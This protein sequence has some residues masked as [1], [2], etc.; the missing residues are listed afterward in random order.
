MMFA[1]N[2]DELDEGDKGKVRAYFL[3]GEYL[4]RLY[5]VS[6]GIPARI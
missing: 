4:L 1:L 5:A 3:K 2:E 6:N